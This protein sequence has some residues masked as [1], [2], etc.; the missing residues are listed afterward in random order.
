M[1]RNRH[2]VAL[3]T[4]PR[5]PAPADFSFNL[6]HFLLHVP[7]ITSAIV[8]AT[9]KMQ[10]AS[11]NWQPDLVPP[12]P[13]CRKHF[14]LKSAPNSSPFPPL[15]LCCLPQPSGLVSANG[16]TWPQMCHCSE[17]EMQTIWS[18]PRII[19]YLYTEQRESVWGPFMGLF[20]TSALKKI[21]K[22]YFKVFV[23]PIFTKF[24][25]ESVIENIYAI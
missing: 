4:P 18:S 20:L 2:W 1:G 21:L 24:L 9:W 8:V 3:R 17:K 12:P 11:S 23:S 16:I 25:R 5:S 6:Q 13:N 14:Y 19:T 10:P 15:L 7:K 22:I